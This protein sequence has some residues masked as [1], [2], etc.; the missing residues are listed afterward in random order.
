MIGSGD[1]TLVVVGAT[2]AVLVGLAVRAP[3]PF[4]ALMFLVIMN[5]VPGVNLR[6]SCLGA[7]GFKTRR[8]RHGSRAGVAPR[9]C[10]GRD[11]SSGGQAR[12]NLGT[13]LLTWWLLTVARSAILDGVPLRY[14]VSYGRDFAYFAVLL[15]LVVR[16]QI[17]K[18]SRQSGVWLAA[19]GIV[20]FALGQVV[21]SV[22]GH[23]LAWLVHP[24]YTVGT[25]GG[26]LRLYSR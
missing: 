25:S 14:A 1:V 13:A 10:R 26:L 7:S 15:V 4:I 2:A 16:V 6:V 24:E 9:T 19:A 11:G 21:S 17:P 5:A 18:H 3:G 20:A 23:T 22:S 8:H 12:H